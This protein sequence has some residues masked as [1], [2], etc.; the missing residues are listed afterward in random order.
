M[1]LFWFDL[2]NKMIQKL[3]IVLE[4]FE[5]KMHLDILYELFLKEWIVFIADVHDA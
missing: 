2:S 3:I 1:E 5:K 4:F